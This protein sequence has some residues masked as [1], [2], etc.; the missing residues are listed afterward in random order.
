MLK[1]RW[2]DFIVKNKQFN[3]KSLDFITTCISSIMTYTNIVF[4]AIENTN[5]QYFNGA[6]FYSGGTKFE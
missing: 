3:N 4:G 5:R 6:R 2:L 1:N